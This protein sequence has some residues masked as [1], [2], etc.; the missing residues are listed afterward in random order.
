MGSRE[1]S[2]LKSGW[3][4]GL[5]NGLEEMMNEALMRPN[6]SEGVGLGTNKV[7]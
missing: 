7:V 4:G 5:D 2:S 3:F 1:D 6:V